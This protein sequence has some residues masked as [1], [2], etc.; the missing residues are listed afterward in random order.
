M[1]DP[2]FYWGHFFFKDLHC[3]THKTHSSYTKLSPQHL[4]LLYQ[5]QV[6]KSHL[7]LPVLKEKPESQ[8]GVVIYIQLQSQHLAGRNRKMD[9]FQARLV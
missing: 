6:Q 8:P 2:T 7:I 9:K 3:A 5:P 4:K 1:R